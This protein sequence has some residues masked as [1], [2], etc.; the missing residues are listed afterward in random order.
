MGDTF[1]VGLTNDFL[2]ATSTYDMGLERLTGTPEIEWDYLSEAGE[3]SASQ[4]AEFDAL[5]VLGPHVTAA[6]LERADRLAVIARFGVGYDK[7][8]VEA[9]TRAGVALTIT[10]DGVRRPMAMAILTLVLALSSRLL[11]KDRLTRAGGWARKPDYIGMGLTGRVLGSIG[12][13]N[14]GR[15]LFTLARPLGMRHIAHDPYA[16][17]MS[18]LGVE[19]VD[20]ET[21]FRTADIV[22]VNCPLTPHTRHL[23]N[24]ERIALMKPT[25]YLINTARG[26]IVDQAALTKALKEN[27]IAGAGLDVY[28]QEPVDPDD[29]ILTLDNVIV[30]P[31]GLGWTD[32]LI[33]VSGESAIGGILDVAAGRMPPH[34]V[35]REVVDSPLFQAKLERY[36][37]RNV[38]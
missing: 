24:A 15:E 23:V 34:I 16:A 10:P 19:L 18:D 1:R 12:A 9:C 25:A 30:A 31:H 11:Q 27:R 3:L 5:L 2:T 36:A 22:V 28:D 35:N 38:T 32:E 26:P 4:V 29:P 21:V 37:A 17:D 14:I 8:D 33:R 7:V 6:S 13:G 20:L